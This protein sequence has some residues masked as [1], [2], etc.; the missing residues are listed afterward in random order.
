L[1]TVTATLAAAAPLLLVPPL[2]LDETPDDVPLLVPPPF[3]DPPPL[4]PP[5]VP[6]L[7]VAPLLVPPPLLETVPELAPLEAPPP[8]PLPPPPPDAVP[9]LVELPPPPVVPPPPA[10]VP[11]V[12]P[13]PW[14][15]EP[16]GRSAL[17]LQA[18]AR[19][20]PRAMMP[21]T[22]SNLRRGVRMG[23]QVLQRGFQPSRA[24]AHP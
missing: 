2:P 6:P 10:P 5:V 24:S 21:A 4:D 1:S 13:V 18:V 20:S 15:H 8:P 12:D 23:T 19:G 22:G 14:C 16:V 3:D 17:P 11:P 9:P 7:E